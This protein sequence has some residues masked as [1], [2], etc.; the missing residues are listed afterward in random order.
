MTPCGSAPVRA[1]WSTVRRPDD[2]IDIFALLAGKNHDIPLGDH[3][4][5]E[6]QVIQKAVSEAYET[7]SKPQE[8][9]LL[10]STTA[11]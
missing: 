7:L 9:G 3:D 2:Y 5:F 8:D 10:A 4:L 1:G 6:A 11:S